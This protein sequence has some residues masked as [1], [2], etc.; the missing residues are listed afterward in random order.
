MVPGFF[1]KVKAT[2]TWSLPPP[3]GTE[4]K[5][6]WSFTS[7]S[8]MNF[9]VVDRDCSPY[10][11]VTSVWTHNWSPLIPHVSLLLLFVVHFLAVIY[12][13]F[14][15]SGFVAEGIVRCTCTV[16]WPCRS[17]NRLKLWDQVLLSLIV[18]NSIFFP[19]CFRNTRL[20]RH[21]IIV[22]S[23]WYWIESVIEFYM[24][25]PLETV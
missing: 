18:W 5:N 2:E 19:G 17:V 20:W 4:V 16:S 15:Q 24:W 1:P 11:N 14:W 13:C 9:H 25:S 22:L 7:A 10:I 8:P 6:G 23:V 3:S 21:R 12:L